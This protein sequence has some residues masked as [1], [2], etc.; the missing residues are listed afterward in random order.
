MGTLASDIDSPIK[1]TTVSGPRT[2]YC[3]AGELDFNFLVRDTSLSGDLSR[4]I[5]LSRRNR[6]FYKPLRDL[7]GILRNN[8]ELFGGFSSV[9]IGVRDVPCVIQT[10]EA[11]GLLQSENMVSADLHVSP[12]DVLRT[13][14]IREGTDLVCRYPV[15]TVL[16][17]ELKLYFH[18]A[19][20]MHTA[21]AAVSYLLNM[22]Q[23]K[24]F[25][26]LVTWSGQVLNLAV[27]QHDSFLFHNAYKVS[28]AGE[29]I[30]FIAAVMKKLDIPTDQVTIVAGGTSVDTELAGKL[31]GVLQLPDGSVEPQDDRW[32]RDFELNLLAQCA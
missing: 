9:I 28:F 11:A 26:M 2:L 8:P 25:N 6:Y 32:Y 24:P 29:V 1:N 10:K 31:S 20:V 13:D 21:T 23:N 17:D 18:H 7:P 22:P 5:R 15:P 30:Y 19:R 14:V 27:S 3:I 12:N 4:D 16:L